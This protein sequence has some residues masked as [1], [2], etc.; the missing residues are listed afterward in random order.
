[1]SGLLSHKSKSSATGLEGKKGVLWWEILRLTKLHKPRILFLEN[2]DRLLKSPASQR[3]RDFAI[4]LASLGEEGYTVEWRVIN[5]AEYGFPQRRRRVFIIAYRTKKSISLA[6][7]L[8]NG[9]LAEA[10]PCETSSDS[11]SGELESNLLTLS[12]NFGKG[13][14]D[15]P[16]KNAGIYQKGKYLTVEVRPRYEGRVK[17]L[18][19][20][21]LPLDEI[22]SSYFLDSSNLSKW[23]YLKGAKSEE[24]T[25][26]SGYKWR[27]SEGSMVFPDPID[28]PSRTILTGEGGTSPSRFKHV[29]SQN[30]RLRRLHPIELERLNGFPDGWTAEGDEPM[31]DVKRA[32]FMGNALVVGL[33]ERVGKVLGSRLDSL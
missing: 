24:R 17:S 27:Y 2:V 30:G 16:F 15:S 5:A 31:S 32:F 3:G 9:V 33:V 22:P 11:L 14:K 10:F 13:L 12:A 20:T 18:A 23:E 4:M 6:S 26:S 29:I 19:D 28:K 1:M 8:E 21:L 25:H 7:I